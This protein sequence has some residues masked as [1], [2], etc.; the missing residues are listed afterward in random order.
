MDSRLRRNDERLRFLSCYESIKIMEIHKLLSGL[1]GK[2][3]KT[4]I[5]AR[6]LKRTEECCRRRDRP[7]SEP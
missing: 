4:D 5:K 2:V 1:Q 6:F 7:S 3:E